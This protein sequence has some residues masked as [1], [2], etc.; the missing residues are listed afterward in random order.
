MSARLEESDAVLSADGDYRYS[1]TR[2]LPQ[3]YAGCELLVV[4]LNPSTADATVDDPTIRR[5]MRFAD[6]EGA[7]W[8]TV[9]NLFARRATN[10]DTLCRGWPPCTSCIGPDNDA[11]LRQETIAAELIVVAWG[12]VGRRHPTRIAEVVEI[13]RERDAPGGPRTLWCLGKTKDGDPRHPLYVR[14][15]QP[16]VEWNPS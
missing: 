6:R 8:V 4:M 11:T 13:L 1:L 2:R 10:P 16:L 3:H 7:G 15:D 5:V 14:A 9:V 12:A